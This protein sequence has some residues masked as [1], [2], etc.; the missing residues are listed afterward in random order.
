[1]R[2]IR[3]DAV[4]FDELFGRRKG[5]KWLPPV[6]VKFNL[7][8]DYHVSVSGKTPHSYYLDPNGLLIPIETETPSPEI[9]KFVDEQRKASARAKAR[10]LRRKQKAA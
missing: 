2:H 9:T 1:M 3:V 10:E 6:V 5:A 4:K 7:G 8:T